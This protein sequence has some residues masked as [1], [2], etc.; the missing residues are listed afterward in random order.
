M[1]N[2]KRHSICSSLISAPA[3]RL[4]ALAIAATSAHAATFTWDG[5]T[6]L[7]SSLH[8]LPGPVGGASVTNADTA[9][10]DLGMV[11]FAGNDTFGNAATTTSPIIN[12]NAGGTLASGGFFN[13]IINLNM[14]GGTLLS[15]GGVNS[16]YGAFALKGTVTVGGTSVSTMSTGSGNFNT[17]SVGAGAGGG[18][19][20]FNVADVTG[21]SAADLIANTVFNNL[22]GTASG[23]VKSGAGTMQLGAANV[24]TGDTVATGGVLEIASGGSVTTSTRISTTN[25]ANL[26]VKGTLTTPSTGI[27]SVGAGSATTGTTTVEA[28]GILSIGTGGGYA[29][30][31]GKNAAAASTTGFGTGLG[32]GTLTINGGAVNVAAAGTG[33]GTGTSAGLDSTSL[34][35]NP[36]G[37]GGGQSGINLNG[38]VLTSARPI[39]NGSANTFFNFNG[40]TLRAGASVNLANGVNTTNVRNGGIIV[41]TNTFSPSVTSAL[42]H[43]SIGGDN[44]IDGGL[45][46]NGAGNLT[47]SSSGSTFTGNV[48]VST[49]TL[50]VSGSSNTPTPTAT[51]LGNMTTAGKTVTIANGASLVFG[52]NDTIGSTTIANTGASFIVNGGTLSHGTFFTSIGNITL[53]SG[54]TMTGG[55]GVNASFQTWTLRGAVTV[56]GASGSTINTTGSSNTGIHLGVN[57]TNVFNVGTTGSAVDL[58]VNAPLIDRP[59]NNVGAGVLQKTGAGTMVLGAANAYTGSTTVSA[60]RLL[61]NGSMPAAGTVTV[62]HGAGFGRTSPG[63]TTFGALTLGAAAANT[64]TLTFAAGSTLIVGNADGLVANGGVNSVTVNIT[65][66]APAIGTYTLLDYNGTL[67]G[68]FSSFVLGSLPSRTLASLVD[69]A[70]GTSIDL[71]VTGVDS[72][73][74]SGALG[75]AWNTGTLAAPKNWVLHSDGA[76]QTDYIEGDTVNFT[77]SAAGTTVDISG[78]NVTPGSTNFNHSTLNYT[79]TG[80][81]GIAGGGSITKTG[82]GTLT[83][84]NVNSYSGGTAINGGLIVAATGALSGSG[85]ISFGGGSLRYAAGNT[86]DLSSRIANSAGAVVLDTNGN[87]IT[88]AGGIGATNTADF[89]KDGAGA[90]TINGANS[91]G[92]AMN[93][94]GGTVLLTNAGSSFTGAL[95]INSGATVEASVSGGGATSA[96]GQANVARTITVNTGGTLRFSNHDVFGNAGANPALT[97]NV[98]GGTV[99]N[100]QAPSLGPAFTTFGPLILNNG[101]VTSTGGAVAGFQAYQFKG[102]VTSSGSS[103]LTTTGG[104]FNGFHVAN[105][106]FNVTGGTLTVSAPLINGTSNSTAGFTKTGAGTMTLTNTANAFTGTVN[107]NGGT[108]GFANGTLGSTGSVTFGGGTLKHESGN[109]QDVSARFANSASAITIDTGGNSLTYASAIAGSNTG[110]LTKTGNGTLT[111]TGANSYAGPTTVTG[112]T[113]AANGT[114]PGSGVTATTGGSFGNAAGGTAT[115]SALTLGTAAADI[116]GITAN[117]GASPSVIVTTTNALVANGGANTALVHI[118]GSA[119]APGTYVVVDYDGTIGG[120]FSSF[121][122]GSTPPRLIASLVNNVANTSV[123]INIAGSDSARWSGALGSAWT[124]ATLGAPKNWVLHSNGTTTTDYIGGDTVH[125]TDSAVSGTVSIDDADVAPAVVNI[126]NNTVAFT[127]GGTRAITGGTAL[128]KTGTA[129]LALNSANTFT[130]N[131]TLAGG[132]TTA[133]SGGIGTGGIAFTGGS[134]RFGAGNTQDLSTRIGNSTGVIAIDTNGNNVTFAAPIAGSNTGGLTKTGNGT[135]TLAANASTFT[136]DVTV[137]GGTL[138][139]TAGLLGPTPASTALGNSN[140]ARAV[141]IGTGARLEFKQHDIL[142]NDAANPALT[143]VVN[144]GTLAA[145]TGSQASGNG[146]FDILPA[147]TLNGGTLTAANGAFA[148]VQSL[149]LKGDITVTGST[150]SFI[151][152]TG[153]AALLDGVHL[154]KA[155]GVNFNVA[156]VTGDSAADLT[157]S[158]RLI[159]TAGAL[160]ANG[161]T[162]SGSGT[163]ILSAVNDYTGTTSVTSGTLLITG[164]LSGSDVQVESGATIG[165]T[166]TAKTLWVKTGGIFSPGASIGTFTA[167]GG[168]ILLEGISNFEINKTGLTLSADLAVSTTAILYGGTLNITATGDALSPGN[169]FNLFDAPDLGGN[170]FS[171]INL[172]SLDPGLYWDTADL[173]NGGTITVIPEPGSAALLLAGLGMLARRRRQQS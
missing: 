32:S 113:L 167:G 170:I 171:A 157:V 6:D 25:G 94:N 159:N 136:G 76:T 172:P 2:L 82:N 23:I 58:A 57:G 31:G 63:A 163:M 140:V 50:T 127:F 21:S 112:G 8:W 49:G 83:I 46:K 114:I 64:S 168:D 1:N 132:E 3:L 160:A 131:V 47:L 120:G 43:S 48:T 135:L 30:I 137:S 164:S 16:P 7:W 27:F 74:W 143:F 22:Q 110:G 123:D 4:A 88:F 108:L 93:V 102:T 40:G 65:G 130:G 149:S 111:L 128:T 66:G 28:G 39:Q 145:V 98:D 9:I 139:I 121:A 38:G 26:V 73:R 125:F 156:N 141:T 80:T 69:N 44:A 75:S 173:T 41:D 84:N 52:N 161:I 109:S 34:W 61:L 18:T 129:A 37:G 103:A 126:S 77:D 100:A 81:H 96:L 14:N 151:N 89:T 11:S 24:Y 153:T 91:F 79:L 33:G 117:L 56:G 142:G 68:G 72:A 85:I 71:S 165:G 51:S 5:A 133:V 62:E 124:T 19:T 146:P 10:I 101:T 87:N 155:G 95:N 154:T 12:L 97:V 118:S 166:G 92:G 35:L 13:A 169:T 42:L 29:G 147:V 119:P 90:L 54:A 70:G 162:K 99:I 134:F 17:I 78:A 115:V 86:Q 116:S 150:P 36:Y 105:N 59:G 122:L 148:P 20:T 138:A 104:T 107:I 55:N 60:G 152:T 15:N 106:T 158:A 144:G 45:T 53:N 67:G